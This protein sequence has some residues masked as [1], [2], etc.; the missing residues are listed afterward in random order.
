MGVV[1]GRCT[2]EKLL[3]LKFKHG[4]LIFIIIMEIRKQTR[5]LDEKSILP[6][7]PGFFFTVSQY[8][9]LP[10]RPIFDHGK[11]GQH[12]TEQGQSAAQDK[13]E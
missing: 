7:T 3:L 2:Q 8:R 5:N 9:F 10:V 6:F 13:L 11:P 4:I 12:F 1:S